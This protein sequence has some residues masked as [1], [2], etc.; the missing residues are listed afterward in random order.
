MLFTGDQRD[1]ILAGRI[2]M[3]VRNWARPQ[4]RVGGRY[5]IDDTH[6]VVAD[7]VEAV[8]AGALTEAD[9]VA[10]GFSELA[11]LLAF[12]GEPEPGGRFTRVAW[13]LERE[14]DARSAAGE[15]ELDDALFED[16]RARLA[17]MDERASGPW[18]GTV[19]ELIKERPATLAA[20]LAARLGRDTPAF[21]A[22]VRKLKAL[23]L[24]RS[25]EVGYELSP[26]GVSYVERTRG[27]G[28]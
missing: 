7:A 14:I 21:K 26:L 11:A 23:G 9:A 28:S 25:L 2:T 16:L 20:R 27:P 3:S 6:V 1:G 8:D 13:H 4:A 5:R 12:L 19:L 15:R 18:T 10:S 17:R 22:D 24:T